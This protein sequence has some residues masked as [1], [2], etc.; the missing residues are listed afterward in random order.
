VYII[1]AGGGKVGRTLTKDLLELGHE[2][3][4]IEQDPMR[5]RI[6]E[7]EFEHVVQLGDATEIF[8]LHQCGT[9]RADLVVAVTGDDE[10]NAIVCQIAREHYGIQRVIA[11]VNDPRNQEAFDLLGI[12]PTVCATAAIK[13]LIEH[14]LPDHELVTLLN[15]KHEN[16]EIAEVQIRSNSPSAGRAVRDIELPEGARLIS[17]KRGGEAEIAVGSTVLEPGD[18]VFAI[19]K[20]GL[21]SELKR[22]LLA[23]TPA[24]KLPA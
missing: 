14:E 6:L 12:Q 9:P 19:L 17:V 24:A 5:Y 7:E 3:T 15:L 2:V 13:A 11:R 21:R 22:A 18:Q 23:S 20:P 16:L 4:L 10:D 1:I 8:M